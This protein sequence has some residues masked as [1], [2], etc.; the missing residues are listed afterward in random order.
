M[1]DDPRTAGYTCEL[2]LSNEYSDLHVMV[3][4]DIDIDGTFKAWCLD[5]ERFL[6]VSGWTYR[7]E[8]INA[9]GDDECML[10]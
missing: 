5:T 3:Q 7:I 6:L 4:P 8:D 10:V 2:W 9:E 1:L